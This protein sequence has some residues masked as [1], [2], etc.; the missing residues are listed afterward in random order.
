MQV[1]SRAQNTHGGTWRRVAER[2]EMQPGDAGPEAHWC[3]WRAWFGIGGSVLIQER[4]ANDFVP[5]PSADVTA[6]EEE[7]EYCSILN[8]T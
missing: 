4:F 7:V 3:G 2:G 5:V 6:W 1:S 8:T